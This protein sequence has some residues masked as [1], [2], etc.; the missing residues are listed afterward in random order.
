[1]LQLL[2]KWLYDNVFN[3]RDFDYPQTL[4]HRDTILDTLSTAAF[5]ISILDMIWLPFCYCTWGSWRLI[6]YQS[7]LRSSWQV[8]NWR[9]AVKRDCRLET[10]CPF[11]FRGLYENPLS[12]WLILYWIWTIQILVDKREEE[13]RWQK[14]SDGQ[15]D[16]KKKKAFTDF[17]DRKKVVWHQ[18]EKFSS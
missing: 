4:K 18:N 9:D 1:M 5:W 13:K 15:E 10:F 14:N 11:F 16:R 12:Y 3:V 7:H 6:I 17:L 8:A 2:N